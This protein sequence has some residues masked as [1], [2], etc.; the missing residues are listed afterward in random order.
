MAAIIVKIISLCFQSCTEL[1]LQE[2]CNPN[3]LTVCPVLTPRVIWSS[4]LQA[5]LEAFSGWT[6]RWPWKSPGRYC[7]NCLI[8]SDSKGRTHVL[9]WIKSEW[10]VQYM[11]RTETLYRS[12]VT[13]SVYT[14]VFLFFNFH[15]CH[16]A[17]FPPQ[18]F[19]YCLKWSQKWTPTLKIAP[20]IKDKLYRSINVTKPFKP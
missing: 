13:F 10:D 19:A 3:V 15:L 12:A 1:W 17:I 5:E 14:V 2:C 11:Q 18:N 4:E 9:S 8:A 20:R 7:F 16:C 6:V